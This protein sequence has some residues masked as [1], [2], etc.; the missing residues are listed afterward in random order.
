MAAPSTLGL[1][2]QTSFT[3]STSGTLNE[4][5]LAH[6]ADTSAAQSA[7]L[8]MSLSIPSDGGQPLATSIM[9]V[10]PAMTTT[11]SDQ[12]SML[13][14]DTPV[15]VEAGQAYTLELAFSEQGR[16]LDAV[17]S[18]AGSP[19]DL[20]SAGHA[21]R[22]EPGPMLAALRFTLFDYLHSPGKWNPA[23]DHPEPGGRP[24]ACH[25]LT[26]PAAQH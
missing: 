24:D 10:I 2:Y 12:G 19:A 22:A 11:P 26:N 3:A 14:F 20:H 1:A 5:Y 13:N 21:I 4:V 23:V 17:R 7:I 15:S 6:V 18:A 8:I 25:R 9:T 16:V